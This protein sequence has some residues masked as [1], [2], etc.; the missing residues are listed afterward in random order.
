MAVLITVLMGGKPSDFTTVLSENRHLIVYIELVSVGLLPL[1]YTWICRDD[2]DQYGFRW[3][4]LGRSLLLSGIFVAVIFA[5]GYLM[6]GEVISD[7]RETLFVTAPWNYWYG[8]S[9]ILVWG[10]LE[11]FFVVWLIENTD[12]IYPGRS[13]L[14][15]W[16]LIVTVVL[17][18][19]THP[20]SSGGLFN[21]AYTGFIFLLLGLIFRY[22]RNIYGPMLAWTLING[23]VWFMVRLL[24]I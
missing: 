20:V 24:F 21:A 15:S 18:A 4:G 7:S 6:S 13:R 14:L 9:S 11:V 17:F 22:S 1:L 3:Q 19:L 23:Q 10:A 12:A 8:L 5:T 16:G 2:L